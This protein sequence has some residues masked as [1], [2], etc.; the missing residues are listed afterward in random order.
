MFLSLASAPSF[1]QTLNAALES[2][3]QHNIAFALERRKL[4]E[5]FEIS[6]R[7]SLDLGPTISLSG[8]YGLQS[9]GEADNFKAGEAWGASVS[10]DQPLLRRGQIYSQHLIASY[11][12]RIAYTLFRKAEAQLILDGLR[13]YLGV[14]AASA[15]L[16]V[17]EK[18]LSQLTEQWEATRRNASLGG[19]SRRDVALAAASLAEARADVI[20]ISARHTASQRAFRDYFGIE[21]DELESPET[22]AELLPSASTTLLEARASLQSNNFDLL[23]ARLEL[24]KQR[25]IFRATRGLVFLPS[26]S[27]QANYS[28]SE[29]P[30]NATEAFSTKL[31]FSYPLRPF[32]FMSG[33]RSILNGLRLARD[34]V[35]LA[36]QRSERGLLDAWENLQATQESEKA[37]LETVEAREIVLRSASSEQTLGTGEIDDLLEAERDFAEAERSA[38]VA[39]SDALY[40]R[41]VFL[42]AIGTLSASLLDLQVTDYSMRYFSR[43]GFGVE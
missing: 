17:S 9:G 11:D 21:E 31:V 37:R 39:R 18:S 5:V 38:I 24:R 4:Q 13:T 3:W 27:L 15:A 25:K 29:L 35:R 7:A 41:F 30:G 33:Y 14:V 40:A 36:E 34:N 43:W 42:Q 6:R 10:L 20:E 1:S 23:A 19:A 32:Y 22:L 28:I 2:S 8:S 26:V 16:R 12:R